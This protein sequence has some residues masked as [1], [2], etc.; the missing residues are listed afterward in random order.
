VRDILAKKLA[1]VIEKIQIDVRVISFRSK[2]VYV[3]GEVKTPGLQEITD[4]PV[5]ILDAVNR[6][7]GFTAESDHSQVLLT[8][9]GTTW[10]VDLQSLYEDGAIG[11][12]VKLEPVTSST[13]QIAPST[14]CSCWARCRSPGPT[15]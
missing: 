14:R 4:V 9:D 15:S 3:V 6:A 10:R 1:K 11:Q 13:C 12:N 2:R 8:R 5:T 7:G